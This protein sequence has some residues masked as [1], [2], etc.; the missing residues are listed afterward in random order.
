MSAGGPVEGLKMLSVPFRIGMF[1]RYAGAIHRRIRNPRLRDVLYQYATYSGASPFKTPATMAVIPWVEHYFGGWHIDGGM[2]RLAEV[3]EEIAGKRGVQIITGA[4]VKQ[5]VVDRAT[6]TASS[7]RLEDG[8]QHGADAIIAN[9]DVVHTYRRLIDPKDR[10]HYPDEKLDSFEPG[11]SGFVL[12]L[13]IE[14]TY[15]QLVHHNKFMPDDYRAELDA[16]FIHQALPAD[17][18]I[19]VCA[20][21]RT[22]PALAPEGCEALFILVSAPSLQGSAIDWSIE[23]PRYR[24]RIVAALEQRWGFSDLSRRIVVEQSMSPA[25]LKSRYNANAGSIYGIASSSLRTSF[26]RPPNRDARIKRLYFAGGATHPGGGL[27]LVALSGK[28]ASDLAAKDL[29]DGARAEG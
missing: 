20:A 9:A 27:P 15:P 21:T 12:M 22:D 10:P 3:L 13:G 19:Y 26:L 18:C 23:G 29:E 5:I 7:V 16:M 24:D 1:R 8:T 6:S 14:G 11:G 2:Y 25:D 28:I 17:P 4:E